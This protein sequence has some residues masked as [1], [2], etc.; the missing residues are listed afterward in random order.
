MEIPNGIRQRGEYLVHVARR[1][2][3]SCLEA[4]EMQSTLSNE[5]RVLLSTGSFY[6]KLTNF[7]LLL[8]ALQLHLLSQ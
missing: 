8:T 7:S 2:I 1:R 3:D 5:A 4:L 6:M